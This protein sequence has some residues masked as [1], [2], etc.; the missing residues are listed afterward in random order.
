MT[1]KQLI[2]ELKEIINNL[3]EYRILTNELINKHVSLYDIEEFIERN[4][5][6][7]TDECF[8]DYD[9]DLYK[10]VDIAVLEEIL[11]KLKVAEDE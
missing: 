8:Y 2:I 10:W 7:S 4:S 5:I 1:N 9:Y 6:E 11:V 3:K